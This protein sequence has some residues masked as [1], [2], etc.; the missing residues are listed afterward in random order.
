VARAALVVVAA[1]H[2]S[3]ALLGAS[4]PLQPVR[5][6]VSWALQRGRSTSSKRTSQRPPWARASSQLA[7]AA[8]TEPACSGP[9]GEGAKRPT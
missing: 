6:Q 3:G 1:A 8:T 9:V 7:S 5:G 4:L 2:G